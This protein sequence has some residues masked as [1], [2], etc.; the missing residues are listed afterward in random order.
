MLHRS[1]TNIVRNF[2]ANEQ[3]IHA[4]FAPAGPIVSIDLLRDPQNKKSKGSCMIYFDSAKSAQRAI[5]MFHNEPFMNMVLVVRADHDK[6]PVDAPSAGPAP[7][8]PA[9][10]NSAPPIIVSSTPTQSRRVAARVEG[11]P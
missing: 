11:G 10:R 5:R 4:H 9:V 8:Q 1:Q 2:K 7:P 6:I 3:A